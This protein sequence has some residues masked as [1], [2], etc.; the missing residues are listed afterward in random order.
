[1]IREI[2]DDLAFVMTSHGEPMVYTQYLHLI[3]GR[4]QWDEESL[5]NHVR[6]V[7]GEDLVKWLEETL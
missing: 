5:K 2:R 6:V 4:E 1:M 3:L 7:Y